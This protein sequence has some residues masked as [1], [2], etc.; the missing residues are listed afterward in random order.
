MNCKRIVPAFKIVLASI[1]LLIGVPILI[2][3][4]IGIINSSLVSESFD[5][6]SP[7]EDRI[8]WVIISFIIP[9]PMII[10]GNSLAGN[11]VKQNKRE[12]QEEKEKE[13]QRLRKIFFD[14]VQ[15]QGGVVTLFQFSIAAQSS[16]KLAQKYLDEFAKEYNA[17]YQVDEEGNIFYKFNIVGKQEVDS[18]HSE[19]WEET[20]TK[21]LENNTENIQ[22]KSD[23]P[24]NEEG[25]VGETEPKNKELYTADWL[26]ENFDSFQEAKDYFGIKAIGWEALA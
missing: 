20:T 12:K 5:N 21:E 18:S 19:S 2:I 23:Y 3:C 8:M 14:L 1:F 11:V 25:N 26:K 15:Q 7:N 17:T 6:S 10:A 24:N 16:G 13:R 4:I 22:S 9:I